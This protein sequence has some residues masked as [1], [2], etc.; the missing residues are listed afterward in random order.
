MIREHAMRVA[1]LALPGLLVSAC[2]NLALQKTA[3]DVLQQM[4]C[5]QSAARGTC[6]RSWDSEYQAWQRQRAAYLR[7]LE[8]ERQ[9]DSVLR[10][11]VAPGSL[12]EL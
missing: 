10:D 11:S 1:I 12:P 9:S 3:H 6:H 2:S 4:S 7:E 8:T 5:E